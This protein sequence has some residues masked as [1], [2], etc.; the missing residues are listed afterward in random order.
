M[1]ESLRY[2]RRDFAAKPPSKREAFSLF[3]MIYK[4]DRERERRL[5]HA[6]P[7]GS[8]FLLYIFAKSS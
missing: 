6:L 4:E 5:P 2:R 1:T 7:V 8:L 3:R